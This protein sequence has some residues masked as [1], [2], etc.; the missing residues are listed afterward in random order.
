MFLSMSMIIC[1]QHNPNVLT[2]EDSSILGRITLIIHNKLSFSYHQSSMN[3]FFQ[4]VLY[5]FFLQNYLK[6]L[7]T[8]TA[9]S[10][11]HI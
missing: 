5:I 6:R 11:Q 8:H 10:A 1:R 4:I 9:F 2:S 3:V 7:Q